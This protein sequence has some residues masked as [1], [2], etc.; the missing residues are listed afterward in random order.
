MLRCAQHDI[1]CHV[2]PFFDSL[3]LGSVSNSLCLSPS[4]DSA[5]SV[6][7][8]VPPAEAWGWQMGASQDHRCVS[9]AW[10]RGVGR[11]LCP[12]K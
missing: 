9:P 6:S 10:E 5:P 12:P 8:T 2:P 11:F 7:Y 3:L 1:T 4:A